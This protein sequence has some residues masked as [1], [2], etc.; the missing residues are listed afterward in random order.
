MLP[1]Y[2]VF[3]VL[4]SV[5][6]FSQDQFFQ[7]RHSEIAEIYVRESWKAV[8]VLWH[9]SDEVMDI[10]VVQAILLHSVIDFTGERGSHYLNTFI[11]QIRW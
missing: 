2:L 1:D 8:E 10:T 6:R 3:V 9:D 7:T 4:A 11:Y 5:A